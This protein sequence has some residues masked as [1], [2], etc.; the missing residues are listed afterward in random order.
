MRMSSPWLSSP[1]IAATTAAIQNPTMIFRLQGVDVGRF[2]AV[3][4]E[5]TV[6]GEAVTDLIRAKHNA[7]DYHLP[8]SK[9]WL[10][11]TTR[12]HEL[13]CNCTRI[14][15]S[16]GHELN[17]IHHRDFTEAEIEGRRQVREYARFFCDNVAGCEGAFVN[18]TGVQVGVM[19]QG[20]LRPSKRL[21]QVALCVCH[22]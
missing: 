5:D 11:P 16:D 7:G 1:P 9:I 18:D 6:M 14:V 20:G 21:G 13:L 10:F 4:G 12:P 8:R 3:Y 22:G 17:A 19:G 15:G 2:R